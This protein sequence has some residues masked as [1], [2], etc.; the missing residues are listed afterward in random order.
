MSKLFYVEVFAVY[1]CLTINT[2]NYQK[3][4]VFIPTN[5]KEWVAFSLVQRNTWGFP[6]RL[7]NWWKEF[8]KTMNHLFNKN[9][10]KQ[11]DRKNWEDRSEKPHDGKLNWKNGRKE[12]LERRKI[13]K[14]GKWKIG[15]TFGWY[16]GRLLHVILSKN[17]EKKHW[18][19]IFKWHKI[20]NSGKNKNATLYLV[21]GDCATSK[22]RLWLN[23]CNQLQD[24]CFQN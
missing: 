22:T 3:T 23:F 19:Q 10:I 8:V 20:L 15:N 13:W 12:K 4:K 24:L 7:L 17:P 1:N 9:G 11:K 14:T 2:P 16:Q 18:Q 21:K 5:K 6:T